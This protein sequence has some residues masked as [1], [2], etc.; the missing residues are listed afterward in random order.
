MIAPLDDDDLRR[1]PAPINDAQQVVV[2]RR[3]TSAS[4]PGAVVAAA[5]FFAYGLEVVLR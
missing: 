1:D 4:R 5:Y 3:R 2:R